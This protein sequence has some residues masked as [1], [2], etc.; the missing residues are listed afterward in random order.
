MTPIRW[1]QAFVAFAGIIAFFIFREIIQL[2]WNYFRLSLWDQWGIGAPDL[3]AVILAAGMFLALHKNSRLH[4]YLIDVI[5][6]LAK[7]TW[8]VKK[9]TLISSVIVIVM[10]SMASFVV[11]LFDSL[12]GSVSQHLLAM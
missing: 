12:W 5:N 7:I 10:V 6:E 8:P 9:E 1:V 3:L 11:F 4:N 2:V